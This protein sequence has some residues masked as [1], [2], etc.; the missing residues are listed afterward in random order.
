MS[1]RGTKVFE[2]EREDVKQ[3]APSIYQSIQ[4]NEIMKIEIVSGSLQKVKTDLLVVLLDSESELASTDDP[5]LAELMERLL[6]DYAEKKIKKEYFTQW[7]TEG[8]RHLLVIHSSLDAPYNI[9]EKVKILSARALSHARDLNLNSVTFLLNGKD[10]P[11]YLGKIVEGIVLG[12]YSFDRYKK[13]KATYLDDL[14]VSLLV[15]RS[16]VEICRAK[17]DRYRI[18]SEAVNECRDI[19]N[20]PGSVVYPEILAD[21]SQQIGKTQQLKVSVLDEKALQKG[22]YA[23]LISVGKGSIHPPRLIT[24][25]YRAKKSKIQLALVGK[26][27]TFDTGGIS[28]K[29]SEKMLEMKGD[30]AGGAAVLYTMKAI[31][32]LKPEINV[33]GIIPSAENFPDANA[34]RPGDI[35]IAKNGKSVQVDNTDAEGRLVLI[36]GFARAEEL[37]ATHVVDIAT[38]TGAVVRAL[39]AGYAGIMGNDQG[40]I[41][42]V[43]QAG[44]NHGENFWQLPLPDEYKDMLKTPYA[45]INNVGGPQ[46]GAITAGLFLQEFI[47]ENTAWA[48][49]DIAGP[50]LF[51]KPWKYYREGATGFGV[52]T[53]VDL[54][55]HFGMLLPS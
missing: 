48:H 12:C 39:G 26:G 44:K 37:K 6:R 30:M 2:I 33:V 14:K 31:A 41:S 38:L 49:L 22:G 40:L 23:G 55:Q 29:P 36:D 19:V 15:D 54:C 20:E 47:P 1:C 13:E 8:V 51:D 10:G 45:D 46:G 28:I 5:Q 21:L 32:Q 16:A 9:W 34:Q 43:I 52:K 7:S 17:Y 50:F 3:L 4:R 11:T 18:V 25:E 53:F 35:F 42:A 24:L 27:I